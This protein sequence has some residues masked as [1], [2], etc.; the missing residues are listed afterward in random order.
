VVGFRAYLLRAQVDD[1]PPDRRVHVLSRYLPY[2]IIFDNVEQWARILA[3]AGTEEAS[4][5]GLSWYRGPADCSLEDYAD[6]IKVFAL[7]LSGVISNTRQF[8]TL[9]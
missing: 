1:I 6:S 3:A 9:I 2:A 4:C 5:Q 8:R 7:T